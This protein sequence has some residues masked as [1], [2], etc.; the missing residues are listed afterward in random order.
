MKCD[1]MK[2]LFQHNPH[3]FHHCL[4]PISQKLNKQQIWRHRMNFSANELF[5]PFSYIYIYIYIYIQ[6]W[7]KSTPKNGL[8]S[9]ISSLWKCFKQDGAICTLINEHLKLADHLTYLGRIISSTESDVNIR[10]GMVWTVIDRLSAMGRSDFSYKI[11]RE[12]FRAVAMLVLL[13]GYTTWTST[14]SMEKMQDRNYT[15]VMHFEH[16]LKVTSTKQ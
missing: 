5:C 7:L 13:Y 8:N 12:F 14:R 1:Q 10:K 2:F 6:L 15:R 11:K 9:K 16:I 4:D 3:I